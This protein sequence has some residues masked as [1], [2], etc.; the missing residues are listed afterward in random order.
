MPTRLSVQRTADRISISYDPASLRKMNITVGKN[1]TIG[2][3][4]ELR[5]YPKGAARPEQNRTTLE[6]GMEEKAAGAITWSN[7]RL[8][9]SA[10]TFI[11]LT[12]GI[13]A[14]GKRYIIEHDLILF[15]TD[16]PVQH[17]WS[18]ASS[19]NYRILWEKKLTAER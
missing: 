17:M 6:G 11:S 12:D 19:R 10:Q 16:V 15:E 4:D 13:P 3:K 8:R 18:P 9:N 1:M 5:V 2:T 14:A 7:S